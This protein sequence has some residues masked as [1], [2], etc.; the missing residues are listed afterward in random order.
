MGA[1]IIREGWDDWGKP[2]N[3]Q[4][5]QFVEYHNYGPG[6]NFNYRAPY[7]KIIDNPT[8][9]HRDKVLNGWKPALSEK[10][11]KSSLFLINS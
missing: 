6:A 2:N 1:H 8:H 3:H 10:E 11:R 5:I 4:T 9:Y 7:T